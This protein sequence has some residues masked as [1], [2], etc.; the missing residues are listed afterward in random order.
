MTLQI[1]DAADVEFTKHPYRRV[2]S[3]ALRQ[4][5]RSTTIPA[6]IVPFNNMANIRGTVAV[7]RK[8]RNTRLGLTDCWEGENHP[9]A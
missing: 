4:R 5:R 9:K 8:Q 3:R 7:K 2:V 6:A 1:H